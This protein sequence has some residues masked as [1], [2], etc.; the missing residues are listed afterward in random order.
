[1]KGGHDDPLGPSHLILNIKYMLPR[2]I[3]STL[4]RNSCVV[5]QGHKK[6]ARNL[7]VLCYLFNKAVS[8]I[9]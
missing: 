6:K 9:V 8:N 3:S 1:M 5:I 7:A 4:K 2:H